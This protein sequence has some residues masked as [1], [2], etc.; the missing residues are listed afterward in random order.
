LQLI[1]I[2]GIH[3]NDLKIF[4]LCKALKKLSIDLNIPIIVTVPIS[5]GKRISDL[6]DLRKTGAIEPFAD[7]IMFLN[8]NVYN[9][10]PENEKGKQEIILSIPKNNTGQS[11]SMKLRGALHVQKFVEFDY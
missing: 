5:L 8:R 6:K 9:H 7:V 10:D 4:T 1:S 3:E 2:E 11:D